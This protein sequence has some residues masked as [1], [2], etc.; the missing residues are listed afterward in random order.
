MDRTFLNPAYQ[1]PAPN[2]LAEVC[3]KAATMENVIDLSIGDPD[4]PTPASF[5]YIILD[6]KNLTTL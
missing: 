6:I 2:L 1:A 3:E 4:L 5:K